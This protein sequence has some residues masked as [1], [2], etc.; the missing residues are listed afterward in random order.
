MRKSKYHTD[1]CYVC[2]KPCYKGRVTCNSCAGII[3]AYLSQNS[4]DLHLYIDFFVCER[5]DLF[6]TLSFSGNSE[7]WICESCLSDET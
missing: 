7:N 1:K 5:C 3:R 6:G 2:W 4:D